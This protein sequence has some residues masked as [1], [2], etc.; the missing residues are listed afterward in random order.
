MPDICIHAN[1]RA[2]NTADYVKRAA[3]YF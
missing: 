1:Y 3:L 2:E